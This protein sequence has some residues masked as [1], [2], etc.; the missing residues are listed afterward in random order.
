MIEINYAS[1]AEYKI[2]IVF[3]GSLAGVIGPY[4]VG[5]LTPNVRFFVFL[6]YSI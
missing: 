2:L 4:I 6:N 1:F 5:I 3:S